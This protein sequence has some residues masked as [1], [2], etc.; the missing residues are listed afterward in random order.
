MK[1]PRNK[2]L[3]NQKNPRRNRQTFGGFFLLILVGV[4]LLFVFRFSYIVISGQV[5][6]EN[7]SQKASALYQNSTVLRA[8]RGTI[9]DASGTAIAE[10]ST[11]YSLYAILDKNH[12]GTNGKKLYVT[13]KAKTARVLSQYL[14][15]SRQNILKRLNP[16]NP[17]TF[18]VE[19]GAAGKGLSLSIK[20]AI[21][22]ANL[23]GIYFNE[24][25]AR[26]YPNGIFASHQVGLAQLQN[27]DEKTSAEAQN[28]TGI[29]GLE[30]T[31]NS[32]LRGVNGSKKIKKDSYGYQLP[33]TKAKE[34]T[35]KNGNNLYLTLDTR[36]Q[37]YLETLMS[38][39][40][41]KYQPKQLNAVLMNPKTGQILAAS[42]RPTFNPQTGSG[43]GNFWR[44][45]LVADAYEP[46]SV[47]KVFT[48]A[49]AI[50]AGKYQPN[51]TY[52]SGQI[53]VGGITIHDWNK[54]GW[55]TIPFSE[56][57]ARS[58]NVGFVHIQQ[59]MGQ[60]KWLRYIK[61]FKFMQKTNSM[62]PGEVSGSIQY[63]HASD[64]A[65]TAFGQGINVNMMQMMQGFSAIAN[66]G[67]EMKPQIVAKMTDPNTGKTTNYQPRSVGKPISQDTAEQVRQAMEDVVYKKYGTGRVYAIPGYKIAAKTGT[68]EISHANGGGYLAGRNNYIFSVVGM[69]P[70]DDPKYVL[71][72]TMKQPQNMTKEASVILS[73]IFNPLM[74]RALDYEQS[75]ATTTTQAQM[76]NVTGKTVSDATAALKQNQL[77]PIQ[78]GTGNTVV[79]QMPVKNEV[80]LD[81]QR[82]L[83]L[84]NGGMTMPDVTGWSKSDILK[85]A[86]LTGKNITTKGTGYATKQSLPAKSLLNSAKSITVTLSK[87]K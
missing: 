23:K 15:L 43:L 81:H 11:T 68:A 28:L 80:V 36:L 54:T 61:K 13:D 34:K 82:V 71:Y 78:I 38:N 41:T 60:A 56:A 33:N 59:L 7:L 16:K 47:M 72:I 50:D 14:P 58:S 4:F 63:Q 29:M 20:Q 55:G 17:N 26:L 1:A 84:T 12:V 6:N 5:N 31:F 53:R 19:F 52:A 49:A 51:T 46:G 66:N 67:K 74:K 64:Q 37:T 42:Q 48:L 85:L 77:T 76:P 30:K 3:M 45:T 69:A 27:H 8:K 86:E 24:T 57:F 25:P 44:D 9:Y 87:P 18:Q 75:N 79:Q 2:R 83:L 22:K 40:Q 70:A 10:D 35:A 73:E 21:D 65:I 32:S 39:A 62:L